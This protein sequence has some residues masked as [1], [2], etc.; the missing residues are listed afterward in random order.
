[1]DVHEFYARQDAFTDPG[2]YAGLYGDLPYAPAELRDI[3][4]RLIIHV[5]WAA[6]YG[7]PPDTP[8][9]RETQTAS[10]RLKLSRALSPGSLPTHRPAEK[11]SFG[12]CRDYS[13]MLCSMLRHH[14][15]PARIRCGF[16]T[17]FA[18]S[19]F[20]D[21]W[22]CEFWSPQDGRWIRA[23][24]QLDQM[25]RDRLGIGFNAADLPSNAFLTAGQAWQLARSGDADSEAFGNGDTRG[26]WFIRVNVCR[27][28]LT[29]TNRHTSA[30]D[31]WRNAS[32]ASKVFDPDALAA[33]DSIAGMISD[34]EAGVREFA[35]LEETASANLLPPW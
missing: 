31:T 4:S 16:A 22:I 14:A 3:V 27:D 17:Y 2:A 25:H 20:E 9:S 6:R 12:S 1:V 33:I 26:L 5:A 10:E 28:L 18:I 32:A 30:W 35:Q 21:H 29:L 7:L 8:M 15:V 24:A 11:R 19:P 23:D 34:F 13:L